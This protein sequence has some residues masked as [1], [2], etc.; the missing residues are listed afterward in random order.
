MNRDPRDRRAAVL[1]VVGLHQ[2]QHRAMSLGSERGSR[3]IG[4]RRRHPF[5]R[6]EDRR[7]LNIVEPDGNDTLDDTG[8]ALD[9]GDA[10]FFGNE[11]S[12][13][14]IG[15]QDHGNDVGLRQALAKD[16]GYEIIAGGYPRIQP[17][18]QT[19]RAELNVERIDKALLVLVGVREEYDRRHW[20]VTQG[21][22]PIACSS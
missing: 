4:R 16:R 15:A 9:D 3:G 2:T 17:Y 18:I 13:D 12:I 22:L 6:R 8:D 19:A 14:A 1:Q 11:R 20:S 10:I 7:H 21:G 5:R